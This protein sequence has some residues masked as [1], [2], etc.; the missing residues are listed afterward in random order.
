MP[1]TTI[2]ANFVSEDRSCNCCNCCDQLSGGL[3]I[4]PSTSFG[5]CYQCIAPNGY[6]VK[7]TFS[8]YPGVL[9]AVGES[10]VIGTLAWEEF[11][12]DNTGCSGENRG[13][14]TNNIT[15]TWALCDTTLGQVIVDISQTYLNISSRFIFDCK[16]L[17]FVSCSSNGTGCTVDPNICGNWTV[18][19]DA[20]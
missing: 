6:R 14:G 5:G 17:A 7:M 3:T 19:L 4:V 20:V 18:T 8:V 12:S 16:T 15:A 13:S 10:A 9:T 11:E 2:K 1:S